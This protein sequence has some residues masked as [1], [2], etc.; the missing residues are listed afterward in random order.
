MPL[1]LVIQEPVECAFVD[2]LAK[3]W[4]NFKKI[5]KWTAEFTGHLDDIIQAVLETFLLLN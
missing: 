3:N 5:T 4:R 1:E 2:I